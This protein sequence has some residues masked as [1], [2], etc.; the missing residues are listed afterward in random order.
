MNGKKIEEEK[1]TT[2]LIINLHSNFIACVILYIM[3]KTINFIIF[4]HTRVE[5]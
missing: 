3:W 4:L 2:F 1:K 5:R